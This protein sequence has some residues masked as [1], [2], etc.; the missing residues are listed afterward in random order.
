[1][2]HDHIG[3]HHDF[4]AKDIGSEQLDMF[5]KFD[6]A[7]YPGVFTWE[8]D[9]SG[10]VT[11][12][13]L[14]DAK[15]TR[16]TC[17]EL[18]RHVDVHDK[19]K[20]AAVF[21]PGG[22]KDCEPIDFDIRVC[23][24]NQATRY[25]LKGKKCVAGA[26]H[27]FAAGVAYDVDHVRA[28]IARLEY[29]EKHDPLTGLFNLR[30]VETI[31]K[32]ST[33]CG[34]NP[35]TMVIANID[36]LKDINDTL[37]YQAGNT[38]IQDVAG[39]IKECFFDAEMIARI[40]GGEYCAVFFGK[41]MLEI[42]LKIKEANMMLHRLYLNLINTEVT[43]GYAATDKADGFSGLYRQAYN[44]MQKHKNLKR[45]LEKSVI[46]RLGEIISSKAGWG[47]RSV[48]LQ[49]LSAQVGQMLGC[50]EDSLQEIRVL[51]KIADIGLIG[52]D[53][54]LVRNRARL[55]GKDRLDYLKHIEYGRAIIVSISEL[56]EME[57][58]YLD[59]HKRYDE[60]RDGLALSSR[61]L[62]GV[63]HFDDIA[64]AGQPTKL[65]TIHASLCREKG[66]KYCPRVVDALVGILGNVT[67]NTLNCG[68]S[69]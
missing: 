50:N 26:E 59:I 21:A 7:L 46:D 38:L 1:M 67:P 27:Y 58:L 64:S 49:C 17:D 69:L 13:D 60:W 19:Q 65:D 63:M 45:I 54:R 37:G 6:S 11:L 68:V 30:T 62:A 61:I 40:G 57:G 23:K 14:L 20:I 39:I 56:S 28:Q 52:L 31:F 32:D 16:Y 2:I 9:C 3:R 44:M 12:T 66:A 47:K 53:D 25:R 22:T 48:R 18:L 34:G 15:G 41:D 10:N 29:L 42:D 5:D 51:S 4:M 8:T 35:K 55:A 24:D 36:N 43:F 33:I